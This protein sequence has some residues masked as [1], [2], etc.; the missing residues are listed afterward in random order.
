MLLQHFI[1][2]QK[3][4]KRQNGY[5]IPNFENHFIHNYIVAQSKKPP[6]AAFYDL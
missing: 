3:N 1:P 6:K 4:Q 5:G 2:L